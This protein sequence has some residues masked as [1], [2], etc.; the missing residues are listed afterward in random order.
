MQ[1][2]ETYLLVSSNLYVKLVSSVVLS[3]IFDDNI[4]AYSVE[5]LQAVLTDQYVSLLT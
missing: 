3:V 5:F 2:F 1:S 4:K